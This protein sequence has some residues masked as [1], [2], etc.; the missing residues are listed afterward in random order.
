MVRE[1]EG[2]EHTHIYVHVCIYMNSSTVTNW[3]GIKWQV[4][5]CTW[6]V[7]STAVCMWVPWDMS[8]SAYADTPLGQLQSRVARPLSR[9]WFGYTRL[10]A[11]VPP[12]VAVMPF[13]SLFILI[14]FALFGYPQHCYACSVAS[15]SS[16]GVNG[17][18]RK[19]KGQD[20][21][22]HT[23]SPCLTTR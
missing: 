16:L 11:A 6:N 12:Y 10:G 3:N 2:Q 20:W 21:G 5:T 1:M 15:L 4:F 19:I 8:T 23:D 22:A 13:Y 17:L 14:V 7:E 9:K 18:T